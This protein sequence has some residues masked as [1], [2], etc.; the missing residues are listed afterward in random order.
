MKKLFLVLSVLLTFFAANFASAAAADLEI[1]TP[2]IAAIQASMQARHNQLL[3]HYGAGAIGLTKDGMIAVKDAS[4]LPLKDRGGIT[5]LVAAENADR[6]KLY[7]EIAAA[8]SHPEW[9]NDIQ[10][11]FAGR[12]IDKAQSGWWYQGAGGWV[13][14]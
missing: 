4:A 7:K 12:W 3:P 11:T 10:N 1:N 14:K 5:G 8:N 9:Q 6:A 13:K 2:A